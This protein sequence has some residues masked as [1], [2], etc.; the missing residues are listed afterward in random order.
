MISTKS[1]INFSIST[2]IVISNSKYIQTSIPVSEADV[3]SPLFD[4]DGNVVGININKSLNSSIS[5][6]IDSDILKEIQDKFNKINFNEI[7][8]VTFDKLKQ[9]YYINS[10]SEKVYNNIPKSKWKEYS[11]IGDVE[12][13]I[14]LTLVKASY[15]DGIVSLRY[16]NSLK[17]YI[18]NNQLINP[19]KAALK[20][21]G[22]KEV[23]NTDK[24]SIYQN[25]KYKV[26]I[27]DEFNYLV[28]VMVKK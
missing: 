12:D 13:N 10:T 4:K 17:G 14:K 26:I 5:F 15:K 27:M 22:Y 2:G 18:D 16:K 8:T 3:G 28:I 23:L 11:K 1:S 19:F 21:S 9:D 20:S 24:K 25:K 6:A 7:K